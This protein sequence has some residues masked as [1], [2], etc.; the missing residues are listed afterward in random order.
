MMAYIFVKKLYLYN[1]KKCAR[2]SQSHDNFVIKVKIH[3]YKIDLYI[4]VH[5]GYVN[6]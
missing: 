5:G 4:A 1:F 6:W 2:Y 3:A